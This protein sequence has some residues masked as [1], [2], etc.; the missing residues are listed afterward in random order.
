M[1]IDYDRLRELADKA[2]PGPWEVKAEETST[3]GDLIEG[4]AA[5]IEADNEL[6]F[7]RGMEIEEDE[8]L[9]NL[10][11]AALAPDM[12]RELLA[13]RDEIERTCDR[14]TDEIERTPVELQAA[15]ITLHTERVH[16]LALCT[17]LL[18]GD[19]E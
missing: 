9:T 12:A 6:V 19:F 13:L 15:R 1:R 5:W 11:L 17:H 4:L 18:G 2:P 10:A 8:E 16:M 7:G 14:I 3:C